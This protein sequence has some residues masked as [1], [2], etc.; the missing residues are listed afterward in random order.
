MGMLALVFFFP[1]LNRLG[2]LASGEDE[3]RRLA[4]DAD[5]RPEQTAIADLQ[6]Q[7]RRLANDA[8]IGHHAV[9]HQITGADPGT[10]VSLTVESANLRLFDLA[11]H[12]GDDQVALEL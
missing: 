7:P 6:L 3:L 12:A 8:H 11:D 5:A 9:V 4:V 10:A 2:H 1:I